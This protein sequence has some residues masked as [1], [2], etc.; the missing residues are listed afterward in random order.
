MSSS[1]IKRYIE[2]YF[3]QFVSEAARP[4]VGYSDDRLNEL[5]NDAIDEERFDQAKFWSKI[6]SL[7]KSLAV[8]TKSIEYK[9][10]ESHVE[11]KALQGLLVEE[12]HLE[13]NALQGLFISEVFDELLK[14]ALQELLVED[15]V[16]KL[17]DALLKRTLDEGRIRDAK[18]LA[19]FLDAKVSP[20]EANELLQDALRKGRCHYA[21]I[22]TKHFDAEISQDQLNELSNNAFD[23]NNYFY[24]WILMNDF[25]TAASPE[26]LNRAFVDALDKKSFYAA[27]GWMGYI[28]AE[29]AQCELSKAYN[30]AVREGLCH[31]AK[32]LLK[33]LTKD[34]DVEIS[35]AWLNEL[36]QAQLNELSNNAFTNKNYFDAWTLVNNFGAEASREQ[37]KRSFVDA[38][39]KNLFYEAKGWMR[40]I[41][42]EVARYELGK[43]YN[44]A[45]R[46]GRGRDV[47]MLIK[48]GAK[49]S[50]QN[51]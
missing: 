12:S 24:A 25:G 32:M 33:I 13:T 1:A 35:Q 30:N 23:N 11:I 45:V 50:V 9:V 14:R 10:E 27:K 46:E 38:L 2:Q 7:K 28:D 26:Q 39:D 48:L 8:L 21:K 49:E 5:L 29:A 34:F 41:D 6:I 47:E 31:D 43:T 20:V 17:F 44:N 22:L 16:R 36:S 18:C 4:G 42:S 40:Y 51:M 37:L 15:F 19:E 3:E